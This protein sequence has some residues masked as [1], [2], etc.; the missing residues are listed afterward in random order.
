MCK[1]EAT[2]CLMKRALFPADQN[3][4]AFYVISRLWPYMAIIEMAQVQ[5]KHRRN[6]PEVDVAS[7]QL[8]KCSEI[9]VTLP[10][11]AERVQVQPAPMQLSFAI[12]AY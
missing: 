11:R 3:K 12:E 8:M 10:S 6:P 5:R 9:I 2:F 1:N 4:G 7:R